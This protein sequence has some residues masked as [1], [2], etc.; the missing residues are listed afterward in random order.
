MTS[1]GSTKLHTATFNFVI[2]TN[3]SQ[4]PTASTSNLQAAY[5]TEL[6]YM[7]TIWNP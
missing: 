4:S 3:N 7:I 2:D 5:C 6:L 1:T